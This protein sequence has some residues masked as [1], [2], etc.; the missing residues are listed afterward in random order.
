M[1]LR[2][3]PSF[4]RSLLLCGI[5]VGHDGIRLDED[6]DALESEFRSR[7]V[8]GDLAVVLQSIGK[9]TAM[10]LPVSRVVSL[11]ARDGVTLFHAIIPVRHP[12]HLC[13]V[14]SLRI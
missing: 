9:L 13:R 7:L 6:D 4:D 2:T 11:R 12:L 8:L 10:H 1:E 3:L 5:G 14:V